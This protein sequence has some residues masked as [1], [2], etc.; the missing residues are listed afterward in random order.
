MA[1]LKDYPDTSTPLTVE[2]L[3]NFFHPI[4]SY[5]E[6]SDTTFD[7]NVEWG[8]TWELDEDGTVLAS[9]SSTN[10]SPFN[11]NVGTIIGEDK[12]TLTAQE[13]PSH[14]HAGL[15]WIGN[16][17]YPVSLNPGSASSGYHLQYGASANPFNEGTINTNTTGGGQ[18]HNNIQRSK[19]VNRWHRTA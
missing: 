1:I 14:D 15:R 13:M 10:G 3:L 19:I 6:T 7:P 5:Y 11:V 12:H 8:G 4:G 9:K 16:N 2:N 17:N 18:P